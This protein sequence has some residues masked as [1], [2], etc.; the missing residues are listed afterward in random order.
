MLSNKI[1]DAINAQINAELWSA[2]L[3]L[4]MSYHFANVGMPGVAN[5]FKIQNKEENDHA[6]ILMDYLTSRDGRVELKAIEGVKTSWNSLTE[7]FEDTYA[8]EQKVTSLINNLYAL[9]SAEND[10]ATRTKLDWFITEQVEEEDNV[11]SILDTL[12]LIGDNGSGLYSFD[13]EMATRTYTAPSI[14][15]A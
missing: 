13:R 12:R 10:Y 14:L 3:Y 7:A 5:W 1:Q 11:R 8:H 6:T 9:A 4:S 2:Y 15:N